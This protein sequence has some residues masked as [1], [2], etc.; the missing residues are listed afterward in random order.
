M[1]R[2]T[3]YVNLSTDDAGVMKVWKE[4]MLSFELKLIAIR[5]IEDSFA[6]LLQ[7]TISV[8]SI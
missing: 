2:V 3:N 8:K 5:P 1:L 7:N 4:L 6:E